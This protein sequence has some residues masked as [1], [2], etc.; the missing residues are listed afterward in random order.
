VT[1]RTLRDATIVFV[2]ELCEQVGPFTFAGHGG[3]IATL[4][5][6]IHQASGEDL[7]AGVLT[8][9]ARVQEIMREW[10]DSA[11]L[12]ATIDVLLDLVAAPPPEAGHDREGWHAEVME[13]LYLCGRRD[14]ST[15]VGELSTRADLP[16][17][18]VTELQAWLADDVDDTDNELPAQ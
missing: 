9:D 12:P 18:F 17:S 3:R 13:L 5:H 14:R 16:A 11:P 2:A 15:L 8:A 6:Q 4:R 7:V 1:G 10:V